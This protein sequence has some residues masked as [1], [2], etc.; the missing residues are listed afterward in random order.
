[1][2]LLDSRNGGN[3]CGGLIGNREEVTLK[4]KSKGECGT[5]TVAKK[6]TSNEILEGGRKRRLGEA[7]E[8][9]VISKGEGEE[10]M[11]SREEKKGAFAYS[12]QDVCKNY[13][14]GF[15]SGIRGQMLG[16]KQGKTRS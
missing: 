3:R 2:G 11:T 4:E 8:K 15:L 10:D 6:I 14:T 16:R 5:E 1:L 12:R 9:G 7:G 13:R